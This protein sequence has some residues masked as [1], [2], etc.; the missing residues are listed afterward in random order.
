MLAHN[1]FFTLEDSSEGAVDHLVQQCHKYLKD[2]EGI[3]FFAA[4]SLDPT[5]DR[6]VND[7]AF[8]VAL[9]VI[10]DNRAAHDKYQVD[11]RHGEFIEANK[12]NW[13]QVRV[14]DSDVT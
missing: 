8:Q 13:R 3:V 11:P 2:H 1:V 4:G 14:F 9:H 5:L 6:D 7:R 12:N 10:F